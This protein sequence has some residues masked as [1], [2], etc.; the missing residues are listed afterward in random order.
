MGIC[1]STPTHPKEL[2][3]LAELTRALP[4]EIPLDILNIIAEYVDLRELF[5]SSI[6]GIRM[7]F[8]I[9]LMNYPHLSFFLSL[10]FSLYI[11][12]YIYIGV[13]YEVVTEWAKQLNINVD[14]K[15]I[16]P[17]GCPLIEYD[18]DCE[19]LGERICPNCGW[20]MNYAELPP[21]SHCQAGSIFVWFDCSFNKNK[22]TLIPT[23][24][25]RCSQFGTGYCLQ[26]VII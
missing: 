23:T 14:I 8:P 2:N 15:K 12:I 18:D 11:Y 19:S 24:A 13:R 7:H 22:Y 26:A 5:R 10:S 25:V 1:S 3:A 4:D 6:I 21:P 9:I 20:H 16:K 17:K